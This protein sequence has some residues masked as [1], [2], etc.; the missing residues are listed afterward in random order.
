MPGKRILEQQVERYM[1][2]RREGY[3]QSA[4]AL[5]AGISE[6]SGRDIEGGRREVCN[7]K[8]WRTRPDPFAEV[9]DNELRVM[10]EEEPA[11][12]PTTLL[13]YLQ[14]QHGADVY[15]N[16]RLRTLQRRV[17]KWKALHGKP[18]EI[19]FLQKHEPGKLGLSDFTKLKQVQITI[20]GE[21][22]DHLL[23]HF[24]LIYSKWSYIK[25]IVG[26]ESYTALAEG[27]QEALW[28][29]GGAP[30]EHRTDSLSAAYKNLD[31]DAQEDITERYE[32]FCSHYNMKGTRNNLGKGHENGGVES[33]H[34][35]I[36]RRIRQALLL[37]GSCDFIS[38]EEY[39]NWLDRVVRNFNNR[40]ATAVK[41]ER[42][43]LQELPKY[44]A[45]DFTECVSVV[46]STG[47]I[48]V[49][50]KTYS[51]DSRLRGEKL[52]VHV[53]HDRLECY[54]GSELVETLSKIVRKNQTR[55]IDYRHLIDS[56]VR[57]PQAF[58]YSQIRD[59]LLPSP[60]Y[61][62]IWEHVDEHMSG[63]A[64]CKFIVGLLYLAAKTNKEEEIAISVCA[65]ITEGKE[66]N[67]VK[68]QDR[69]KESKRV[70]PEISINQHRLSSYDA[71][72]CGG[73]K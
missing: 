24:R 64:A 25:V 53:Y 69:Y 46:S 3:T 21:P 27:L 63:K 18:K 29:L 2:S 59:D 37:R 62:R 34:G 26:G 66:L 68:M 6:R 16:N 73:A 65:Q 48:Q 56:L 42:T 1:S 38:I 60:A 51:V 30:W 57:K 31:K 45:V 54:L 44:K 71:L 49:Q 19:M 52:R 39:Q 7:S 61:K 20:N 12:S 41:I 15:P 55:Q 17:K 58:R 67:L 28:R 23:Y 9:W 10:L 14:D 32:E 33:P 50:R 70:I 43:S 11:L 22:F 47:T 13:E 72:L 5:R 40:Y 8:S 36:K 35:H 4:S